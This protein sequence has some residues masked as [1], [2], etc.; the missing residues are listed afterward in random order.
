MSYDKTMFGGSPCIS[1]DLV[2]SFIVE[3]LIW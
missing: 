3:H 2:A 1:V